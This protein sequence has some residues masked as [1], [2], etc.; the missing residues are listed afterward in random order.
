[1][2]KSSFG[3]VVLCERVFQ[4]ENNKHILCNTYSGDIVVQSLPAT[5]PLSVYLEVKSSRVGD[6]SINVEFLVNN[7]TVIGGS[8]IARSEKVGQIVVMIVP[9]FMANFDRNSTI[10]V[11][12]TQEGMQPTYAMTKTVTKGMLPTPQLPTA[13]QQQP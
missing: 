1:M 13:S 5:V 2:R 10:K 7:Q 3:N 6:E 4:G 12:V 11:K 8:A 9:M